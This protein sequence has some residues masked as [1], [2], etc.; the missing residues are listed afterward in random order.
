M[1][2]DEP[3]H[4][5]II[6]YQRVLGPDVVDKP[7][8]GATAALTAVVSADGGELN[9]GGAAGEGRGPRMSVGTGR[10]RRQRRPRRRLALAR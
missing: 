4:S 9:H 7:L 1:V 10:N 8:V 6:R 3:F 5:C 2:H